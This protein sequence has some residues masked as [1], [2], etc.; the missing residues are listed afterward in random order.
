MNNIVKQ[1]LKILVT[2]AGGQ[3]GTEIGCRGA[4]WGAEVINFSRSQLDITKRSEIVAILE[5][6]KPDVLI[7]AAAYTAVDAAETEPELAFK[8]NRDASGILAEVSKEFSLPLVHISTDYVFDGNKLGAYSED[9][10]V[11]PVGVYGKSKA[12][13]EVLIRRI[14]RKHTILRTSWVYA[15]HGGNFVRTMLRLS[16][17]REVLN[18]VDDQHGAPTFA[19]DIAD[20]VLSIAKQVVNNAREEYWGTFHYSSKNETTWRGF[21]DE[22]FRHVTE[23]RGIAPTIKGISSSQYPTRAIRPLNSVLN[24]DKIEK[25]FRVKRRSWKEG[26]TEVM[27]QLLKPK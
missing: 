26:L 4:A 5:A 11:C 19:G 12:A 17:D 3:V 15:A 16:E 14:N 9:D 22:I 7:N 23:R 13:G 25:I 1:P 24:C 8:V 6:N 2:G 10:K 27:N 18:I 21:A 20:A